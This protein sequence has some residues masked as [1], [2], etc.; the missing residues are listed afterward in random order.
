M[1]KQKKKKTANKILIFILVL[2]ILII[3]V[4]SYLLVAKNN[5]FW[6]FFDAKNTQRI[7]TRPSNMENLDSDSYKTTPNSSSTNPDDTFEPDKSPIQYE[8]QTDNSRL[9][10][11]TAPYHNEQF[12]I[13]E[14]EE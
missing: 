10:A 8:S 4:E 2:L 7:D 3:G 13:P 6:P 1:A 12:R 5:N 11:E 14:G 9:D